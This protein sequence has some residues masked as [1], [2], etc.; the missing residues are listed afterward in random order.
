MS[1]TLPPYQ[2]FIPLPFPHLH[3]PERVIALARQSEIRALM[4]AIGELCGGQ[5]EDMSRPRAARI[6]R[7]SNPPG[8]TSA[9]RS[10]PSTA[11][12][13]AQGIIICP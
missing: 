5:V 8:F 2:P 11:A 13:S 6:I 1:V 3:A 9:L 12:G 10:L 4:L 7:S